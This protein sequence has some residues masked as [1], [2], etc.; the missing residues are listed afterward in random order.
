MSVGA[1]GEDHAHPQPP[2][3]DQ[4]AP[5]R[6]VLEGDQAHLSHRL[7]RFE[8]DQEERVTENASPAATSI[9]A[10]DDGDQVRFERKSPFGVTIWTRK[11]TELTEEESEAWERAQK[12]EATSVNSKPQQSAP[13]E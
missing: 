11:K 2:V 5:R 10:F 4:P 13:E 9:Q 12:A 7:V 8:A 1:G 3:Y 6:V